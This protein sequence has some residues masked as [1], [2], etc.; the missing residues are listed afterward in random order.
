D[1][2][3]SLSDLSHE[4]LGPRLT[5]DAEEVLESLAPRQREIEVGDTWYIRT[6]QPYRTADNRLEGVVITFNDVSKMKAA[7]DEIRAAATKFR[8]VADF[9]YDWEYWRSPENRFVY[10]TPSC[11]R[12]TG[13]TRE[14]FQKDPQLYIRIIHPNDR[15]R[16]VEHLTN[17]NTLAEYCE[18]EFRIVRRDGEVRWI[19]HACQA[20]LGEQGQFMGRR[21]SNRDI[22]NRKLAEQSLRDERELLQT[23]FD[24][25]P[26]MLSIYQPSIDIL[27]LNRATY[28]I[29]GWTEDD[30]RREGIMNLA[31]PDPAYRREVADYMQSLA[32]GFKDIRMTCKDGGTK[33][34]SW[35]N[36][37]IPDGRQV[38]IGIDVS[39]RR[40][41]V[42]DLRRSEEKYRLLFTSTLN[43][44]AFHELIIDDAGKPVD[45]RFIDI[46]PAFEQLTGLKADEVVGRTA[47]EVLPGIE[48]D[49][50]DWIGKFGR[51]A[52]E[53]EEMG[54]E[55]FS[56]PLNK[57]FDVFAFQTK[58]RHFCTVFV[59][60]SERKS[61][62][63][64]Q[65]RENRIVTATNSIFEAFV[66]STGT[67]MYDRALNALLEATRSEFGVFGYVD[68][69]GDLICPTMSKL[70][71]QCEV[72][73][74]CIH[75]PRDEWKGV[76][77]RALHEKRTIINNEPARIPSGH[78]PITNNIAAP[79]LFQ[80]RVVGL[81]NFANKEGG[82]SEEDRIFIDAIANEIAPVLYSW[83]QK[84]MRERERSE[85]EY[86][87]RI[88]REDL[89]RAQEV[90]HFGS[91]RLNM[92]ENKLS[93]S[94]ENYR[95]FGISHGT[96][97][98]YE[99]FLQR[100]HPDDRGYVD[101]EWKAA[102]AGKPYDIEHRIVVDD[103]ERWVR[104]KAYLEFDKK[105]ELLAGFG[106]TQDI[107]E[108]KKAEATR[109]K[110][111]K[112][113]E[114]GK[115][116]LDALLAHV[117]EG[118][119]I[120]EGIQKP[121]TVSKM[122]REWTGGKMRNGIAFGGK[123]F[124]RAW[125][126]FHPDTK[127]PINPSQLPVMRVL[128]EGKPVIGDVWRQ[129]TPNGT[130]RYLSANAGP[131]L[132]RKGRVVGC[133][134]AW[135]DVTEAKKSEEALRRR[136]EELAAA[137]KELE[138][139]SYS[140]S[141]DLRAPLRTATGFSDF[142]LE[143]YGDVL[144]EEGKELVKR[145][146]DSTAKMN[147]LIDDLLSLSRISRQ[148]IE[149][150]EV[151]LSN[152]ARAFIE[153]LK[154]TNPERKV[155]IDIQE[156]LVVQG[157]PR[158]LDLAL[159]NLLRNAWKYSGKT[160][161]PSIEFGAFERGEATAYYVRD[162]GAGFEPSQAE[163]LFAPFQRLHPESDFPGTGVGLAIVDRVIRRHG[164]RV[165]AEG[166][167][168]KGACFYFILP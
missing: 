36:I 4:N 42:E 22:T 19:S 82:Y 156:H 70:L 140:V 119:T 84:E 18:C 144:D 62:E 30:V 20:V 103:Q 153:E 17:D 166:Q 107:T 94:D 35:A 145:I 137:N 100:V 130:L 91:W 78:V 134:V 88:N 69:N 147:A 167:P 57:W 52:L 74:K 157:D 165:W 34:T 138:S 24:A 8:I 29:T 63:V 116:I 155:K 95:I 10:M 47:R 112:K 54:F 164:G 104:E 141:H 131:I 12:I 43:G 26:V 93:W 61:A 1:I 98:T 55:Q 49:P 72:E 126:L 121:I 44:M 86:A 132:D 133:V 80:K 108:R 41:M 25:I 102:L 68:E 3:R 117:P 2:G 160:E 71:E 89:N 122:L 14:E 77:G 90:A 99:A 128:K 73:N 40:R 64:A 105:G 142:L 154:R 124:V 76:W 51:V 23:I 106:I 56:E 39:E 163:K 5:E 38:G 129:R 168:G 45:Y 85:A 60:V 65:A 139:F 79:I 96:S 37:R 7:E 101:T 6:T 48:N 46:N 135:R 148:E 111:L 158:L 32:P 59:D 27:H 21:V 31:Y 83:I 118:I 125:G 114:E 150:Q 15:E 115:R 53:G 136:T 159:S 120:T 81:L 113:A 146:K 143:D 97:M 123:E 149:Y 162:N 9:T 58:K 161:N 109:E 66:E 11:E 92:R 127:E 87:L 67:E 110:L 75:Y 33:Q 152:M 16:M 13:Y 151:D 28:Q 50:F